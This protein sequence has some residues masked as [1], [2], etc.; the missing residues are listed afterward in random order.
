MGM[1]IGVYGIKPPDDD[2][3]KM[4]A[5]Y[6]ACDAAGL[7]I[8]KQV[9]RY[10]DDCAPDPSGVVVNLLRED[11]CTAEYHC[12]H[13]EGYE[14]TVDKLPPGVKIVRFVCSY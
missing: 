14:V 8:P 3:R 2:W 13:A 9:E 7:P 4:K 11:R 5:V 1:S 10:F 12:D 6:D